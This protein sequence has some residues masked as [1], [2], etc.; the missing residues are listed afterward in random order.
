M[1]PN[2]ELERD[3]CLEFLAE[4]A[5]DLHVG[6]K[7]ALAWRGVRHNLSSREVLVVWSRSSVNLPEWFVSRFPAPGPY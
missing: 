4:R 2:D 6:G 5:P 1:F 7:S 3:A